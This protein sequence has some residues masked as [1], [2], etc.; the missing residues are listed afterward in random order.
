MEVAGHAGLGQSAPAEVHKGKGA[1]CQ[2]CPAHGEVGHQQL[3]Q[4]VWQAEGQAEG[5]WPTCRQGVWLGQPF[6]HAHRGG[7][8]VRAFRAC[9]HMWTAA[10]QAALQPSLM[11]PD[12]C[13]W[14]PAA[15][16]TQPWRA[17]ARSGDGEGAESSTHHLA[18][19]WCSHCTLSLLL[20][21]VFTQVNPLPGQVPGLRHAS[22]RQGPP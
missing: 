6:A 7:G 2:L 3:V 18:F 21:T 14:E 8:M 9:M 22:S 10:A 5:Q 16:Q 20:S 12:Q 19:L 1:V 15:A 4:G 13:A 17:T 11:Q